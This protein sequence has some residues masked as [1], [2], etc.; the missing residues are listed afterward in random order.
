RRLQ[1]AMTLLSRQR[2]E[3][4]GLLDELERHPLERQRLLVRN[5]ARFQTLPL[6]ELLL[7]H[8]WSLG[9]EEPLRAELV[10]EL[11]GE[12][13][14]LIEPEPFSEE[15]LNDL[16][17]R[18]WAFRGNFRRITGDFRGAEEAFR[19]AQELQGEGTGDLLEQARLLGLRATL[20]RDRSRLEEAGELLQR[21][22]RIY[23]M[24]EETHLAG[25]TMIEMGVLAFREQRYDQAVERF[26]RGLE[27][28]D[29]EQEPRLLFVGHYN[30]MLCLTE[31]GRFDEAMTLLPKV[32]RLTVE[33]GSRFDL[34]R[35]RWNEGDILRGL[36]HEARAEA[37]YLEVR[38]GFI[39]EG[40]AYDAAAVS[41]T[42]AALYLRQG[43]HA[44]IKQL[45]AEMVPIFQ[46][47]D[48]HQEAIAALLLFRRA[49]EMENLTLRMIEEVSEVVRRS[50]GKPA[51][52]P[53]QPS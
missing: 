53:E 31:E 39:E 25:R 32:R 46:S 22:A 33:S 50:Q 3:A 18:S 28:V 20:C 43:R 14:E 12:L 5:N 15:V 48:V 7:D 47:R 19:R 52:P 41:L 8:A 2:A 21:A 35:L 16:R 40:I 6:A 49:V 42:L 1:G 45:A 51:P 26:Q 27:M 34:L 9:F 4:Q 10:A 11:A 30:M 23:L 29:C 36:G 37:A 44:E 13:V 38:K 17:A 24:T